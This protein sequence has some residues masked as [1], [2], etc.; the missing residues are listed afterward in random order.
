MK[1]RF[2]VLLDS[3]TKEQNLAFLEFIKA[4]NIAWWHYL[5]TTWLLYDEN[6]RVSAEILR[7]KL[8]EL[9]PGV[10]NLVLEFGPEGDTWYGYG[11]S[12]EN[13]DMFSWLRSNW[14]P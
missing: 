2:V 6:N 14:N 7:N 12:S 9:Y 1:M 13:R 8:M 5:N 4:S 11:P 3:A 10:Y